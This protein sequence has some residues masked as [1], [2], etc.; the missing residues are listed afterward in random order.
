MTESLCQPCADLPIDMIPWPCVQLDGEANILKVNQSLCVLLETDCD[1]FKDLNING[2]I[3]S[4]SPDISE[5]IKVCS[6]EKEWLGKINWQTKQLTNA[7]SQRVVLRKAPDGTYWLMALENPLIQGRNELNARSELNLL[8]LIL[9]NTKDPIYVKDPSSRLI[10]ANRAFR[11]LWQIEKGDE[12]LLTADEY[13]GPKQA[14]VALIE[15]KEAFESGAPVI[16]RVSSLRCPDGKMRYFLSTKVPVKNDKGEHAALV[17]VTRDISDL[18]LKERQLREAVER[19]KASNKAKSQFLANMSHEIR[20]PINGIIGMSE[21]A[22]ETELDEEQQGYL[23]TVQNCSA[24]LLHIVNDIL[25]F[26]KI[27]AG[28]LHLEHIPFDLREICEQIMDEFSPKCREKELDFGMKLDHKLP[29]RFKG[30]PTRIKQVLY[31]LVGNSVKF[32]RR[33][34]I[35]LSTE[36]A[37]KKAEHKQ[38]IR[39][40]V[41]DTGVGIPEDRLDKVFDSFTQSDNSTTR[42]YGGTGLGLTIVRQLTELMNGSI[43][44]VSEENKGTTFTV[45]IELEVLEPEP[46]IP[47]APETCVGARVL[48]VDDNE[49][50]R[51]YFSNVC[52]QWGMRPTTL[53]D[54]FVALQAL[55]EAASS[56]AP[57]SLLLLDHHMPKLSGIDLLTLVRSRPKLQGLQAAMLSSSLTKAESERVRDLGVQHC[58]SK[59][60][61]PSTLRRMLAEILLPANG[62]QQQSQQLPQP[63]IQP[64]PTNGSALNILVAED[65]PVNQEI[66]AKRLHKMGHQV[67]IVDNGQEAT[68]VIAKEHYDLVLMDL[69]MP[70]MGGIDAAKR[71]RAMD[72][73]ASIVP[74][75]ALTAKAMPEDRQQCKAVGMDGFLTKPFHREKLQSLINA[76]TGEGEQGAPH[77]DIF[78]PEPPPRFEQETLETFKKDVSEW[79]AIRSAAKTFLKHYETDLNSLSEAATRQDWERIIYEAHRFKGGL[80]CFQAERALHYC[81]QIE[82]A[83]AEEK[84]EELDNLLADL[85]AETQ[86]LAEL[87]RHESS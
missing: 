31:N 23:H 43:S 34:S 47:Q 8:E 85:I 73:D 29:A 70:V 14:K 6:A 48:I 69:N 62:D 50:N 9:G 11:D 39:I 1:A 28:R 21:L 37:S 80:G 67:T 44:V 38:L 45:E 84:P 77:E 72:N 36:T 79:D 68:E 5:A 32:T 83:A 27:E 7:F 3:D 19:E 75:I 20:T 56:D 22:L 42:E 41:T 64:E 87:L 18:T 2:L 16:N 82:E 17:C 78:D 33:G 55:E 4:A 46:N 86:R 24:T 60:I 10:L 52:S 13:M 74:I 59:P 30:D 35:C 53:S 49:V 76:I 66:M 65:N 12:Y 61:R 81:R 25:D 15:D 40:S 51:D 63:I 57:Y 58:L 54:G 26:S 71:I